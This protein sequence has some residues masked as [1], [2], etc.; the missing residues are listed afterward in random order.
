MDLIIVGRAPQEEKASSRVMER[1]EFICKKL[2]RNGKLK[3]PRLKNV[4]FR[5]FRTDFYSLELVDFATRI[6]LSYFTRSKAMEITRQVLKEM[7]QFTL[8]EVKIFISNGENEEIFANLPKDDDDLVD[9][10]MTPIEDLKIPKPLKRFLLEFS[11]DPREFGHWKFRVL[12]DILTCSRYEFLEIVPKINA[13]RY[14][15]LME[16]ISDEG[17]VPIEKN[18]TW[19]NSDTEFFVDFSEYSLRTIKEYQRRRDLLVAQLV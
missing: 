17:L 6:D 3:C 14:V 1:L 18:T 11:P 5:S 2:S 10:M 9:K 19:S 16:S 15:R 4:T 13:E 12:G 8:Y 7:S